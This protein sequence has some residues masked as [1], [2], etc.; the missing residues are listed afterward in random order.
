MS[1]SLSRFL[2]LFAELVN[3]WMRG[4]R[5]DDTTF[6]HT[7]SDRPSHAAKSTAS[8]PAMSQPTTTRKGE[9][10]S[11]VLGS[12]ADSGEMAGSPTSLLLGSA[13]IRLSTS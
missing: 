5:A 10:A 6:T 11:A 8:E 13:L 9:S 2:R 7:D 4:K 12:L 3:A 1:I